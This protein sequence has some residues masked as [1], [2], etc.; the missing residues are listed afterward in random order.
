MV[1]QTGEVAR[2]AESNP[3]LLAL[4]LAALYQIVTARRDEVEL[5][6]I[7]SGLPAAGDNDE[8][9]TRARIRWCARLDRRFGRIGTNGDIHGQ[10]HR[11]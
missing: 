10:L 5:A 6:A 2:S 1:Q 7:G 8:R 11:G 3:F 9:R 4:H